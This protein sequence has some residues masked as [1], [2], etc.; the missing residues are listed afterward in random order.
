MRHESKFAAWIRS[1]G[2]SVFIVPFGQARA[3]EIKFSVAPD[4]Y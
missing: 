4:N 3:S 2:S 1:G